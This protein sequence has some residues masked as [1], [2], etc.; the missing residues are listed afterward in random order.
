MGGDKCREMYI[1]VSFA[2]L[3]KLHK[4]YTCISNTYNYT[5]QG[6]NT[7]THYSYSK[8]MTLQVSNN[9]LTVAVHL[10]WP[11]VRT[12]CKCVYRKLHS[13]TMVWPFFA[14]FLNLS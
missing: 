4:G 6:Q 10:C 5:T 14:T 9:S 12:A 7:H 8:H 1:D 11:N 13:H 3:S 2:R